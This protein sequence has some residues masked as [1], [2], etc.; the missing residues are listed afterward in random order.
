[1]YDGNEDM[2]TIEIRDYDSRDAADL[3]CAVH[4]AYHAY[5]HYKTG[6]K[7]RLAFNEKMVNI[8]ATKW[9][10][11]NLKGMELRVALDWIMHSKINY[12]HN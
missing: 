6:R 11:K 5:I 4:E 3:A 2:Y 7:G 9:L 8:L 10:K 12:G 1:M